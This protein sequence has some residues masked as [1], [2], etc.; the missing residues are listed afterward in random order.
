MEENDKMKPRGILRSKR[1]SF[2]PKIDEIYNKNFQ[3]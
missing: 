3:N 2:L 1:P